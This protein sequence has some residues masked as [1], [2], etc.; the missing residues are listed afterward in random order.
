MIVARSQ[1]IADGLR[2][3]VHSHDDSMIAEVSVQTGLEAVQELLQHLCKGEAVACR[4][5]THMAQHSAAKA[6]ALFGQS[7]GMT[8]LMVTRQDAGGCIQHVQ[9]GA[10]EAIFSGLFGCCTSQMLL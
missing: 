1:P 5:K 4:R 2:A 7:P 10:P 9:A 8:T 6:I 3:S